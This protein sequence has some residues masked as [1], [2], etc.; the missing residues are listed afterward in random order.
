[1]SWW[2]V[3]IVAVFWTILVAVLALLVWSAM[4]NT[5]LEYKF[6]LLIDPDGVAAEDVADAST[7][8]ARQ[9]ARI[10]VSNS[11]SETLDRNE[12]MDYQAHQYAYA[13]WCESKPGYTLSQRTVTFGDEEVSFPICTPS[14]KEACERLMDEDIR[15]RLAFSE[16]G[17]NT[18]AMR[19]NI[20][21]TNNTCYDFSMLFLSPITEM[22]EE[23]TGN[24]KFRSSTEALGIVSLGPDGDSD[25]SVVLPEMTCTAEKCVV[26]GTTV[27]DQFPTCLIPPNYC[28]RNGTDYSEGPRGTVWDPDTGVIRTDIPLGD[29]S[30][31]T[32]QFILEIIFGETFVRSF[33]INGERMVQACRKDWDSLEC[34]A[35]MWNAT[36]GN[37]AM[38]TMDSYVSQQ[39]Q[40]WANFAQKCQ[41]AT[42]PDPDT[43][44]M[45]P[46]VDSLGFDPVVGES[47]RGMV[48]CG[49][50][51]LQ[52][53][54]VLFAGIKVADMLFNL[55]YLV[56]GV[57]LGGESGSPV[58]EGL[59][60]AAEFGVS[61][62]V[63]WKTMDAE[64]IINMTT[65]LL[66]AKLIIK[67]KLMRIG[68]RFFSEGLGRQA[69]D[70][71]WDEIDA[72]LPWW[73]S[74]AL[75]SFFGFVWKYG[76]PGVSWAFNAFE[77]LLTDPVG[78]SAEAYRTAAIVAGKAMD[79]I[80]DAYDDAIQGSA[81]LVLSARQ[82]ILT[83]LSSVRDFTSGIDD[84]ANSQLN[85]ALAGLDQTFL[86]PTGLD[87]VYQSMSDTFV[88][89]GNDFRNGVA[90]A[91]ANVDQDIKDWGSSVGDTFV[92]TGNSIKNFFG[93]RLMRRVPLTRQ[94]RL[95]NR[96]MWKKY[97]QWKRDQGSLGRLSRRE[98]FAGA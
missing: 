35:G 10:T 1:M 27:E 72:V 70:M 38:L 24:G 57:N 62:V 90:N 18:A 92:N 84:F 30:I 68:Y 74:T 87:N 2:I 8:E 42:Q 83:Q 13:T 89:L 50:A 96:M 93:L 26:T 40:A 73:M 85:Q 9:F 69:L 33:K 65:Q 29:C 94:D 60:F 3:A 20:V 80:A 47:P 53:H 32:T 12:V 43:Q 77:D 16:T 14:T 6:R 51:M 49:V 28:E 55:A 45:V 86:D 81:Q 78:T 34:G 54:P 79:A 46:D 82:Q 75:E 64:A 52:I 48:E 23:T 91:A 71:T 4:D 17:K 7:F 58:T 31:S 98:F 61:Y 15:S 22:C 44:R 59:V 97:Q 41:P 66:K 21:W 76:A 19:T 95:A 88:N 36:F 63:A 5:T 56:F 25:P 67:L 39:R 11:G 37:V